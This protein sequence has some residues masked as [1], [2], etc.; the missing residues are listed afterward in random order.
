[1]YDLLHG[2]L[3]N[4]EYTYLLR[5]AKPSAMSFI[6]MTEIALLVDL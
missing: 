3:L 1:M 6:L 4:A 5:L 2:D